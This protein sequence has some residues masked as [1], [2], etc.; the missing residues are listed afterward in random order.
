MPV[1]MFVT[2]SQSDE[3]Q[4]LMSTIGL[5]VRDAELFFRMLHGCSPGETV[6]IKLFVEGCL[7][8]RGNASSIDVQ[9]LS[10]EVR[11]IRQMIAELLPA[12]HEYSNPEERPSQKKST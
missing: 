11:V 12:G 7:K 9:C 5:D 3:V 4:A 1:K 6:N 8:I 10:C 2:H